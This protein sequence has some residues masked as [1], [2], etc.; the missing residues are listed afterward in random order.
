METSQLFQLGNL[1]QCC[2]TY[3]SH[4]AAATEVVHSSQK[5]S[6]CALNL[7]PMF[8]IQPTA[9]SPSSQDVA[10]AGHCDLNTTTKEIYLTGTEEEVPVLR[11]HLKTCMGW[12]DCVWFPWSPSTSGAGGADSGAG[13]VRVPLAVGLG[14]R[15]PQG[16]ICLQLVP[17]ADFWLFKIPCDPFSIEIT[18]VTSE[19]LESS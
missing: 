5:F 7:S 4:E 19:R 11:R 9:P 15:Q 18:L 2:T 17:L 6:S 14:V 13:T 12:I 3:H 16:D 10:I 8:R 1:L